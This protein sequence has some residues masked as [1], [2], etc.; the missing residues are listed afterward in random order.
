MRLAA[1]ALQAG[2]ALLGI[3]SSL[4]PAHAQGTARSMDV[5][6]SVRSAAL[7]GAST[8]MFWGEERNHWANP[9]VMGYETD[10]RYVHGNSQLLPNLAPDVRFITDAV[11][12]GG[13]GIGVV[14]SGQPYGHGGVD[15][16]YGPSVIFD[17]GNFIGTF[18]SYEHVHSWGFGVNALAALDA[19]LHLGGGAVR[20]AR[21][22]DVSFGMNFKDTQVVF[23]PD[24]QGSATTRDHGLLVRITPFDGLESSDSAPLRVEL[25][26]GY[27]RINDDDNAGVIFSGSSVPEPVSHQERKGVGLHLAADPMRGKWPRDGVWSLLGPGL[28]PLVSAGL[29][30]D[31]VVV[32]PSAGDFRTDGYGF[33]LA[34]ARVFAIRLGYYRDPLGDVDGMSWGWSAGLPLGRW[35][36]GYYEQ[37]SWPVARDSGLEN[38]KREAAGVWL[39]P[40]AIWRSARGSAAH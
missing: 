32:T 27:S 31:H 40:V 1:A 15:L 26:I 29:T 16:E 37:A 3:V 7:G 35:A 19:A 2:L 24:F 30:Y 4:E 6:V 38:Q 18:D 8:A 17:P 28:Q 22:A 11:K 36:G 39:D 20:M 12:F 14:F 9:A 34:L 25:A 21:W 13:A 33:E 10:I 5:D 23:A